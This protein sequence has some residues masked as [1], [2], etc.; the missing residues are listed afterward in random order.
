MLLGCGCVLVF[1]FGIGG[2]VE[3]GGVA[4]PAASGLITFGDEEDEP[5]EDEEPELLG[6][7]C[8]RCCC[9]QAGLLGLL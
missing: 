1:G 8:C 6:F 3:A 7:A 2:V 9:K 5:D 4:A